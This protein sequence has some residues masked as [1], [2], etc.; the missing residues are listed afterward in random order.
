MILKSVDEGD[1]VS[2][3]EKNKK[4]RLHGFVEAKKK[5]FLFLKIFHHTH[6]EQEYQIIFFADMRAKNYPYPTVGRLGGVE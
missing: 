6:N 5:Q 2:L 1:L 3:R 4:L